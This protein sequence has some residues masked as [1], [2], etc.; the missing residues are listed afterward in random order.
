MTTTGIAGGHL[1]S[2]CWPLNPPPPP[3]QV[4]GICKTIWDVLHL[5]ISSI[6]YQQYCYQDTTAPACLNVFHRARVCA[7]I[8]CH[9]PFPD[10]LK[11]KATPLH[12]K[13]IHIK[14]IKLPTDVSDCKILDTWKWDTCG[15]TTSRMRC[16]LPV[17]KDVK[18]TICIWARDR[19]IQ[20]RCV[21]R[22]QPKMYSS[23]IISRSKLDVRWMLK[24]L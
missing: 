12:I 20:F 9:L 15:G 4:W 23:W 18:D 6:T 13:P 5:A 17:L 16:L 14:Q 11:C 22:C 2:K 1:K 21:Y 19:E 7:C 8:W 3:L 24:G 10:T